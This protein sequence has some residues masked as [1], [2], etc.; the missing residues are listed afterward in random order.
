MR[1]VSFLASKRR[2]RPVLPIQL[3]AGDDWLVRVL[4]STDRLVAGEYRRH[5]RT[6]AYLGQL[7]TLFGVPATTRSWNT[8]GAILRASSGCARASDDSR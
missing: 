2:I 1:F 6:I 8:I 3:P 5:M 7:D 4:S